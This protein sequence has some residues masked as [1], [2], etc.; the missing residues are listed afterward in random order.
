MKTIYIHLKMTFRIFLKLNTLLLIV[1]VGLLG[2]LALPAKASPSTGP[3]PGH[4]PPIGSLSFSHQITFTP[5]ATIYGPIVVKP[6]SMASPPIAIN[7]F[8]YGI[9]VNPHGDTVANIGHLQTLGLR[10]VKFRM[11]WKE[12]EP[13]PGGFSWGLWDNLINAYSANG[14]KILLSISAAPDWARPSDDD[15]SVEGLP[16]DPIKYAQ[17]VATVAARYQGKVRAI[18]IWEGQNLWHH[19][20]GAG[21]VDAVAYTHLL[22]LSYVAVKLAN[23]EMMVVGGALTPASNVSGLAIDDLDYLNQLY[24]RGVTGY[25][26]ALGAHPA[27]FNCPAL[28]DWRTVDDPTAVNFRAPFE[29][30][31]HR[32]CFLGTMEGYREIVVAHGDFRTSIMVTQFGWGVSDNPVSGYEYALDNTHA[33]QA[34]W[35]VDAYQW[36]KP[37]GWVGPMFLWNLDFG[38]NFVDTELAYFSLL[39]P[40]GPTPAYFDLET[41]PK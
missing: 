30:R 26:D 35:M 37:Q 34:Q 31:H 19:V 15:R 1:S 33:E 2:L 36:G 10:W 22:Q 18:E 21:R 3:L 41:L 6:V 8:D 16:Q 5:V 14:I 12:V 23:P 11:P 13:S 29:N 32:W 7:P 39:T 9:E 28:A 38:L 27:G 4:P 24:A 20:G 40:A 25:F 17:F